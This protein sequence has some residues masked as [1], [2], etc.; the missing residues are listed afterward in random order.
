MATWA[1]EECGRS[2]SCCHDRGRWEGARVQVPL[3]RDT[4]SHSG[5]E[6]E[7]G[8]PSYW[9]SSPLLLEALESFRSSSTWP[10]RLSFPSLWLGKVLRLAHSPL[11]QFLLQPVPPAPHLPFL[12]SLMSACR[13]PPQI[14]GSLLS[15]ECRCPRLRDPDYLS[16]CLCS[17]PGVVSAQ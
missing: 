9:Q 7:P 17:G 5:Q 2:S 15:P 16:C 13:S 12:S 8:H 14:E 3:G 4:P 1:S 11:P 6:A 10:S